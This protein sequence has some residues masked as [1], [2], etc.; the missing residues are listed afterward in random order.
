MAPQVKIDEIDVKILNALLKDART[1]FRAIAKDCGVSTPAIA[2][3][4]YK[5][6]RTG[7]ITGAT[8][9]LNRKDM[10]YR[11]SLSI[12]VTAEPTEEINI[13]NALTKLP[14]IIYCNQQLGNYDI[15]IA[16]R[17]RT[18]EKID[19][20]RTIVKKLKGVKEVRIT[21]NLDEY[22]F[23]PENIVIQPTETTKNG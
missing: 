7:V 22:D 17:V 5:L 16:A 23:F 15:H 10:G 9:R 13:I 20:I 18:F 4:F 19:D 3:R 8:I 21:A 1:N 11:C 12:D 14:N 2:K 6:K